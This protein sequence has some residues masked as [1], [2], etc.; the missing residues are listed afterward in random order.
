MT[1]KKR[2][3]Q[4]NNHL[5]VSIDKLISSSSK[6]AQLIETKHQKIIEGACSVLF[7]KGYHMTTIR[8]IAKACDMSMG[9]LYH[10]ISSKDDVL[11]LV[12]KHMQKIWYEHLKSSGIEKVEDPLQKLIDSLYYTI[13][14]IN[15]NKK[16]FQFIYTESKHL[17]KRHLR[18]VLEIDDQNVIG[19]W[20]QL[21]KE[22]NKQ[23]PIPGDLNFIANLIAYLMVF[24]PLR[25]WNLKDRSTNKN[26]AFLIDFILRGLGVIQ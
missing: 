7:A 26:L 11:Y 24:L 6:D 8:E 2:L 10:Y 1:R 5:K 25:G 21:L 15:E 19:F 17:D 20:H 23:K 4:R 12:H 3:L 14:F 13:E 22:A 18:V 9:Q 16:L